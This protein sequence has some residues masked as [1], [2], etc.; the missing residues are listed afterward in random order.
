MSAEIIILAHH[1]RPIKKQPVSFQQPAPYNNN[2]IQQDAATILTRAYNRA[3][4]SKS[5]TS[6]LTLWELRTIHKAIDAQEPPSWKDCC[7]ADQQAIEKSQIETWQ[8]QLKAFL[9]AG[10]SPR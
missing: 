1:K 6:I 7:D 3:S 8:K 5:E 2:A 10:T 4:N 9:P